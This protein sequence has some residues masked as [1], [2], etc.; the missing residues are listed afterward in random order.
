VKSKS[1]TNEKET[2]K[3]K[4]EE[5]L[6]TE[7]VSNEDEARDM[8]PSPDHL[9]VSRRP[10][11]YDADS[12]IYLGPS[13]KLSDDESLLAS[14]TVS[15]EQTAEINRFKGCD[16][17]T[18]LPLEVDPLSGVYIGESPTEKENCK[19]NGDC[20]KIIKQPDSVEH[21]ANMSNKQVGKLA[22][23]TQVTVTRNGKEWF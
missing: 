13:R 20:S 8:S 3:D 17:N 2:S 23:M 22:K 1:M 15:E 4:N 9:T 5:H 10:S 11:H 19:D 14:L 7:E 12:G 21:L 18:P 16:R 6:E